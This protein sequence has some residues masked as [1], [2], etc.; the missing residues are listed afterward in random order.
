MSFAAGS[1]NASTVVALQGGVGDFEAALPL[2]MT[3]WIGPLRLCDTALG[4]SCPPPP[5]NDPV[6]QRAQT[7]FD[8]PCKDFKEGASAA[9][10]AGCL[11]TRCSVPMAQCK[12][13]SCVS[14]TDPILLKHNIKVASVTNG[15]SSPIDPQVAAAFN[16]YTNLIANA[17]SRSSIIAG[18]TSGTSL[19]FCYFSPPLGSPCS[20]NDNITSIYTPLD[21]PRLASRPWS[22]A[23]C[24]D[25]TV[26]NTQMPGGQCRSDD[27]CL[28]SQC[29]AG[30]CEEVTH[31]AGSGS[32]G[33]SPASPVS[34]PPPP[35]QPPDT[36]G[37][38]SGT[39]SS[40][41]SYGAPYWAVM[42]GVVAVSLLFFCIRRGWFCALVRRSR[43]RKQSTP[44]PV[45]AQHQQGG[46]QAVVA[47]PPTMP[48]TA[49]DNY[50]DRALAAQ[51]LALASPGNLPTA[52]PAHPEPAVLISPATAESVPVINPRP[53]DRSSEAGPSSDA[54]PSRPATTEQDEIAAQSPSIDDNDRSHLL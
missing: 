19:G 22:L 42:V 44:G 47:I 29:N 11:K 48:L 5:F 23:T 41:D 36:S 27:M 34:P 4:A 1:L 17:D 53:T 28:L 7:C 35:Q 16:A 2:G 32:F 39:G 12:S 38:A 21:N 30:V 33:N 6:C 50:L 37:A 3:A 45:M 20:G 25:S 52:V 49:A 8:N 40:S 9:D 51:A 18:T 15:A 54:G 46:G 13:T 31:T 10:Y 24:E 43:S 26:Q 14:W